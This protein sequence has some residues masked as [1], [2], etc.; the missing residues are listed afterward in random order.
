MQTNK[1]RWK[2]LNLTN[3]R[4]VSVWVSKCVYSPFSVIRNRAARQDEIYRKGDGKRP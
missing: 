3:C 2:N 4:N 1:F